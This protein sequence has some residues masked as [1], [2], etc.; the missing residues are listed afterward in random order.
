MMETEAE[1]YFY[2]ISLNSYRFFNSHIDIL[3]YA[4]TELLSR[5][6]SLAAES[7]RAIK[8]SGREKLL[9]GAGLWYYSAKCF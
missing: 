1:T 6:V 8:E 5:T 3:F 9:R 2:F 7:E 4:E